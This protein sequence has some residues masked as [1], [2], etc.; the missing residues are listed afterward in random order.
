MKTP[1]SSLGE[2]ARALP[3]ELEHE[4]PPAMGRR[5]HVGNGRNP[6]PSLAP[7]PP[8]PGPARLSGKKDCQ[9]QERDRAADESDRPDELL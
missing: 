4:G 1:S 7:R 9:N 6:R 5:G 2:Q 8:A 3:R